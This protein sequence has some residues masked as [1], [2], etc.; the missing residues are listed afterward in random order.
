ME[1]AMTEQTGKTAQLTPEEWKQ[2]C[3]LNVA[4]LQQFLQ[5]IPSNTEGGT[6]GFTDEH[7][8]LIDGHLQR[9]RSFLRAWSLARVA[10]QGAQPQPAAPAQASEQPQPNGAAPARRGGWPKGRKRVRKVRA[11]PTP[12]VA[13]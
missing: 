4:Q 11:V 5:N 1:S 12:Q 10:V 9:G 8:A 3:V 13:Q 7:M 6:S 2:L